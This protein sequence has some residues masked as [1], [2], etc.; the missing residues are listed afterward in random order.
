MNI[1]PIEMTDLDDS[2]QA[3]ECPI[4]NKQWYWLIDG[5]CIGEIAPCR[6]HLRFQWLP[7]GMITFNRFNTTEFE[8]AYKT[9]HKQLN[10]VDLEGDPLDSQYDLKVIKAMEQV[11][12][13]QLYLFE[14]S[15]IGCNGPFSFDVL[16]GVIESP[17]KP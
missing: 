2:E 8:K 15:G 7:E 10:G 1:F 12:S 17:K 13:L 11:G 3:L 4:C 14:N 6:K 16:Y 5:E 9:A